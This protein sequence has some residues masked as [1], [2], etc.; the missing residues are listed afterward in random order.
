MS[1]SEKSFISATKMGLKL[2]HKILRVKNSRELIKFYVNNFGME[3]VKIST[4]SLSYKVSVLGYTTNYDK[5][6]NKAPDTLPSPTL[7]EFHYNDSSTITSSFVNCG[8]SKV[9]WK[10]GITLHD[11]GYARKILQSKQMNVIDASQFEDIGV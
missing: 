8:A 5:N 9:Y 2:T 1:A 11:V 7:L 6:F 10:I 3:E 4:P